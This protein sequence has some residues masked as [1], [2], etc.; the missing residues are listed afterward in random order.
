[1]SSIQ[2]NGANTT[3]EIADRVVDKSG[4]LGY[5]LSNIHKRGDCKHDN[6]RQ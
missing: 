3:G 5:Y 2:C 6:I 1:M 4:M